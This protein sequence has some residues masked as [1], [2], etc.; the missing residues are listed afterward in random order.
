M[1]SNTNSKDVG[2][3]NSNRA[4]PATT[5]LE[6][7]ETTLGS[8]FVS[9]YPPFSAWKKE[10]AGRV[11]K[12]LCRSTSNDLPLGLYLHIPFCRK[13]CNF[14]YFRVYTQKN[15]SQIQRYI[16]SLSHELH[17]YQQFP[18]IQNR[19][20]KFIY[21]GGG[22]PSL[23]SVHQL[24]TLFEK[25]R[26]VFD[27]N[28]ISEV[29]FECEPGT[30]SEAKVV[31]IQAF[32]VTR[33]SLGVESFNDAVLQV[34]GRAHASKEIYRSLLWIKQAG[35]KQ[36]N[37]DLISGMVGETQDSW[38]ES[39]RKTIDVNPDS[40][41][42]YQMEL[43]YNTNFST[44]LTNGILTK[45]LPNWD[46]KRVWHDYAIEE[47][48]KVGYSFSS[49][50]TMVKQSS[51]RFVY[52]D[53]L[54]HGADLIGAGV[55]SFGH[56]DGVHYQNESSWEKYLHRIDRDELP[57]SRAFA[58]SATD[59]L[60]REMVLQLKLGCIDNSYFQNKFNVNILNS[61]GDT[62]RELEQ[63]QMLNI[64]STRV[65]LTREGLLR[66]DSLL[67]LFYSPEYQHRRYT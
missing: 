6:L 57:V 61:Y 49:A 29:T 56:L 30:L 22:T 44:E 47:L 41:T 20:L 52:R 17:L 12:V 31:A 28:S 24:D 58:T 62:F 50:Y 46:T 14:C 51:T 26:N 48:S 60:T 53:S 7:T 10:L 32:G 1:H 15:N 45:Q 37:I 34:N 2:T 39:V 43:P 36:L 21:F 42:I 18:A 40:V 54:W 65:E 23:L 55:S 67:P 66:V 8:V 63:Q 19:A 5:P 13:R 38:R 16:E 4:E 3:E 64:Y 59:Q 33:L 11:Q 27:W 35:F 9:N 25:I